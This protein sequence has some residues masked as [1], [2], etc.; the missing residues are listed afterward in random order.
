MKKVFSI[1]IFMLV[2]I[3]A[4][5]VP[6]F[7]NPGKRAIKGEVVAVDPEGGTMTL[8]T[9]K[10]EFVQV[11]LPPDINPEAIEVGDW[12][13]VKGPLDQDGIL[14]AEWVKPV[15]N[16]KGKGNE[17]KDEGKKDNSAFCNPEKQDKFHPLAE[18]VGERY[19]VGEQ[20]VMD[21]FCDGYGM[22][23]IMLALKTSQMEGS[24]AGELLEMR[25]G[26]K[27]WGQIWLEKG[28]VGSERE[29]FSPPGLLKKPEFAG[30]KGADE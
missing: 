30:P 8:E 18:K 1:S 9:R 28:L 6:G 19:A 16:G 25:A 11:K 4:V 22:G 21:Y 27:G 17:N 2:V 13:L 24:D 20:W 14:E 23:A 5:A 10:T 29:G 12:M 3:L 15:G 7:A 26:G